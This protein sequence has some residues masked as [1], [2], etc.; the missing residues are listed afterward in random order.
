MIGTPIRR[1]NFDIFNLGFN[2]VTRTG[3]AP[4]AREKE[5]HREEIETEL[6]LLECGKA[7]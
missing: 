1:L 6:V 4:R 5:R 7:E 2:L 3:G